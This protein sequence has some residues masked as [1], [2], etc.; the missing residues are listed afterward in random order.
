MSVRQAFSPIAN[1]KTIFVRPKAN[2][3]PLDGFRA[4]SLLMVIGF[5][6]IYMSKFFISEE[7]Y[8]SLAADAPFY[9]RWLWA[10]DL[11][12][13]IFFVISGFLISGLLLQEFNRQ[14]RLNYGQFYWRRYLRLSPVYL[15]FIGIYALIDGPNS[16]NL[17]ANVFYV[18]NFLDAENVA[19]SWTWS[20]AVEEQFYLLFP[21]VIS[22]LVLKSQR[23]LQNLFLLLLLSF[24]LRGLALYFNTELWQANM[25]EL[26]F[27][28]DLFAQYFDRVYDNLYT[29]YGGFVCGAIAAYYFYSESARLQIFMQK[30]ALVNV[31]T[32]FSLL[33][34]TAILFNDLRINAEA[35]PQT[36]HAY[37][38]VVMRNLFSMA[39]AWL[40][41]ACL[42]PSG[43]GRALG[44]FLTW[45]LWYPLAQLSYSIYLVHFMV[46]SLLFIV[47]KQQFESQQ[48]LM[49]SLTL[50][51]IGQVFIVATLLS[52]VVATMA[53]LLIEKPFMNLRKARNF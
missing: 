5:H 13:D 28:N 44:W 11:A 2:L 51:D 21:F 42:I 46:I 20:L 32:A 37:Y 16:Q 47:L 9:L 48:R 4:F 27:D 1:F 31:L 38:L 6:S 52:M 25:Q 35:T 12:V 22:L 15:F 24:V 7:A 26:S 17:W 36:V 19:M 34:I 18:N 41:I 29:R 10:G 14:G 8:F 43:L 40:I 45:R 49:D 33:L 39:I 30:Q 3:A 53:F 50:G 23:P